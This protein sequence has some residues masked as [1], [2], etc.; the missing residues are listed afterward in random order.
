MK[1]DLKI[2]KI[3]FVL[4]F[5]AVAFLSGPVFC[6]ERSAL[7]GEVAFGAYLFEPSGSHSYSENSS[8][9]SLDIDSGMNLDSDNAFY[10]RAK[11]EG[12]GGFP[13]VSINAALI[14]SEGD[15][16][17]SS[18]FS[19][20]GETFNTGS[21]DSEMTLQNYDLSV[22]YS[23]KGITTATLGKVKIDVGGTFRWFDAEC[24]LSQASGPSVSVNETDYAVC[25]YADLLVRPFRG[26]EIALEWK[27][28]SFSDTEFSNIT[29]RATYQV[30]GPFFVGG[31]YSIEHMDIDQ[32]GFKLDL[33]TEG[34]FL[35]AG[36]RF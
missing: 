2:K 16:T 18:S 27:G 14:N 29:G 12:L 8:G 22:F 4:S 10:G 31:G 32:N 26:F 15:G 36:Y 21:Y 11:F 35:E 3:L 9:T 25:L 23:I 5:L 30:F 19:Y 6:E 33:D 13:G 20:G 17:S 34:A 7:R 1:I 24:E 28:L